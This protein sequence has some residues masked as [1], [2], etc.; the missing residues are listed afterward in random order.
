M[1]EKASVPNVFH[2]ASVWHKHNK[3]LK[4]KKKNKKKQKPEKPWVNVF[5]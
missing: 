3:G 1:R 2:F 5:I 4:K